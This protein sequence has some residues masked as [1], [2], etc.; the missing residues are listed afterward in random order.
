[1]RWQCI[2]C[3]ATGWKTKGRGGKAAC[4]IRRHTFVILISIL[5]RMDDKS[6]SPSQGRNPL[7]TWGFWAVVT[8]A[9]ALI[10]V[11]ILIFRPYGL[12]GNR[13]A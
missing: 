3:L 7:H 2:S 12:F 13:E 6:S 5:S 1:M 4:C 11:L 9:A 8:G 10:M